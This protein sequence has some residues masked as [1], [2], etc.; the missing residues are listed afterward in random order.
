MTDD[1][2]IVIEGQQEKFVSLDA[3]P[4]KI[5]EELSNLFG[6][7]QWNPE[8]VCNVITQLTQAYQERIEQLK[9]ENAKYIFKP[10][11]YYDIDDTEFKRPYCQCCKEDRNKFIHLID[12]KN[13]LWF[14]PKCDKEYDGPNYEPPEFELLDEYEDK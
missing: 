12:K 4:T 6:L 11:F 14:C 7:N 5:G 1:I 8:K 3:Q 10:P 2:T 9:Q 13:D